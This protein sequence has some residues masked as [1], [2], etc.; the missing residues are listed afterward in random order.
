MANED[1]YLYEAVGVL[2]NKSDIKD[3]EQLDKAEFSYVSLNIASLIKVPIAISSVT[4]IKRVL[5]PR[6]D[7]CRKVFAFPLS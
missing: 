6:C 1:I 4:A 7:F 3:S 2:K 5:L